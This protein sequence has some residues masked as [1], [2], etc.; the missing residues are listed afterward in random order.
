MV[1]HLM[2]NF[3]TYSKTHDMVNGI[4]VDKLAM[5]ERIGNFLYVVGRWS[6]ACEIRGFHFGKINMIIGAEHP[7]TLRSMNNLARVLGS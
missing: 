6:E 7:E 5:V 3:A 2:A 4:T 1:P